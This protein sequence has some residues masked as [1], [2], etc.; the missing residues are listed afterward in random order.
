MRTLLGKVRRICTSSIGAG[1]NGVCVVTMKLS[2]IRTWIHKIIRL[3]K[4]YDLEGDLDLESDA[5]SDSVPSLGTLRAW[6]RTSRAFIQPSVDEKSPVLVNTPSPM[7]RFKHAVRMVILIKTGI[8]T[9]CPSDSSP[10]ATELQKTVA[11]AKAPKTRP[12]PMSAA[13]LGAKLRALEVS[14][15]WPAHAGLIRHLQF[16]PSGSHLASAR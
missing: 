10:E 15:E 9:A 11:M 8:R 14:H 12:I 2:V 7:A 3:D 13:I 16:S 1:R 6:D 4:P 5:P